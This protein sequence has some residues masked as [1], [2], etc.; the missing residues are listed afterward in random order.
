[1]AVDGDFANFRAIYDDLTAEV[2][3]SRYQFLPDHLANWFNTL[4]TTSRVAAI[5]KRLQ[6][7]AEFRA[8][9][10]K[11]VNRHEFGYPMATGFRAVAGN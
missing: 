4:D 7:G 9:A 5:V 11:P 8:M 1:M 3:R 2:D 6:S 10:A